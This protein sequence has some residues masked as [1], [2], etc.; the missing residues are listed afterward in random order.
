MPWKRGF[1][2]AIYTNRFRSL[3]NNSLYLAMG[4]TSIPTEEKA[5]AVEVLKSGTI[6]LTKG[7][8][9]L[10]I[11]RETLTKWAKEEGLVFVKSDKKPINSTIFNVID[12][13][14]KAY[15]LGFLYADGCI[16]DDNKVELSL[17]LSDKPH[18]EKFR[19]FMGFG[20]PVREDWFRARM[21]FQD[22]MI[23]E[24]LKRLG[25]IPRK[26]LVLRFPTE[27]QVPKNLVIP[28]I[29][30]YFDGDGSISDPEKVATACSLLG[31]HHFLSGLLNEMFF[32]CPIKV[33]THKNGSPRVCYFAISGKKAISFL[34]IIYKDATVFLERKKQ[35]KDGALIRYENR[36]RKSLK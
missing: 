26:S 4:R 19:Q 25:C 11:D 2:M 18:V 24:D 12:T 13:E 14:E 22:K 16:S 29:R 9:L 5:R 31:T 35:R 28:F 10:K 7:A 15:W 8:K 36:K 33:R 23:G 30:G 34:S 32:M 3:H 17:K 27:K 21:S 6:S 1:F 20:N